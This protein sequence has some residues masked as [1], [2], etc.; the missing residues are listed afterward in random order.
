MGLA[1]ARIEPLT[2]LRTSIASLDKALCV[3]TD[4]FDRYCSGPTSEYD[5][6]RVM[7]AFNGGKDCT[8]LL[9]L[10]RFV[11]QSLPH[12]AGHLR[13]VYIREPIEEIFSEEDAFVRRVSAELDMELIVVEGGMKEGLASLVSGFPSVRA[14]FMGTRST[15]PN[16]GWMTSFCHTS[17]GWAQVDLIA[18]LL[19]M[20]YR[21]VWAIIRRLVVPYCTLYD[22]GYTSIGQ[23]SNTVPNPLLRIAGTNEYLPA[24]MLEDES[25]ERL[26]RHTR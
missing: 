22:I 15:D 16:A 4:G 13:L 17:P 5:L 21:E 20:S 23:R 9:H 10:V 1:N 11:A 24:Y 26:G 8:L 25:K 6:D 2:E 7:I 12:A 3:V 18:P 19:S 14:I